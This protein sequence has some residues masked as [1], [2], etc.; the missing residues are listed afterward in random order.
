MKLHIIGVGGGGCN[1]LTHESCTA[2]HAAESEVPILKAVMG[3]PTYKNDP[4]ADLCLGPDGLFLFD[5]QEHAE[6]QEHSLFTGTY[7]ASR[8]PLGDLPLVRARVADTLAKKS[9][10]I[11]PFFERTKKVIKNIGL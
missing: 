8:H 10:K 6:E 7:G 11:I 9:A 3:S 2:L 5:E 1:D 4:D